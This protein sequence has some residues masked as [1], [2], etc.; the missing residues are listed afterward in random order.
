MANAA[1][2]DCGF[3][4]NE[5]GQPCRNCGRRPTLSAKERAKLVEMASQLS[6]TELADLR[7][8]KL[9]LEPYAQRMM[10][11]ITA[12]EHKLDEMKKPQKR[13]VGI[14]VREACAIA[15]RLD[16]RWPGC[17]VGRP[18]GGYHEVRTADGQL[19]VAHEDIGDCM[20]IADK[21]A[22]EKGGR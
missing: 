2:N 9:P 1:C 11:T 14:D 21:L 16:G 10:A 22:A 19:I 8:G 4:A 3:T 5:E 15:E 7:S 12:L 13:T 17:S 18:S 6:P 20:R